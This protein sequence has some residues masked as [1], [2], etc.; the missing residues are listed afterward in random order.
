MK[1]VS[2]K[3]Q[4]LY[5]YLCSIADA[6]G[7]CFPHHRTIAMHTD[8]TR[9]AVRKALDELQSRGLLLSRERRVGP[10]GWNSSL[11]RIRKP[12]EPKP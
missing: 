6:D 9:S 10:R 2:E 7:Y 5:A 3:A 4:R 11:Y 8:L 12:H 1:E